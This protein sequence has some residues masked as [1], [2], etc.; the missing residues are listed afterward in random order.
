MFYRPTQVAVDLQ[1]LRQNAAAIAKLHPDV[2]LCAVVKADAYGHGSVEIA[3]TLADAGVAWLAVALVE[4]GI[5]LREA[6]IDLPILV[7]GALVNEAAEALV[8]FKLIPTVFE[9]EQLEALSKAA[10][11]SSLKLHLKV[12]TGMSRLGVQPEQLGAFLQELKNHP[13]LV[14]DGVMTHLQNADLEDTPRNQ[15]QIEAFENALSQVKSAGF[16]PQHRHLSNSAATLTLENTSQ[17]LLRPGLV[18]YGL[19]PMQT[20]VPKALT[21]LMR[22]T[23]RPLQIKE[24][25]AGERVS[26]GGH[27]VAKR[28]TKIAVLPVGYAD[29]YRRSFEGKAD[30]LIQGRR[31]P[32]VGSIC[33]DLCMVDVTDFENITQQDEVVLMGSQGTECITTYDLAQW[34]GTIAYEITCG[35]SD[36]VPRQYTGAPS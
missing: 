29:G 23:T 1:A 26:Y 21:P 20:N 7:L 5:R 15:A 9:V 11:S 30:V 18:M 28:A 33:M 24:I 12:D 27:F 35:I 19:S 34:A 36:R 3:R 6:G 14:L 17:N 16:S 4:E 31:A 2:Q 32:I 13:N 22:W 8:K 10:G 25:A